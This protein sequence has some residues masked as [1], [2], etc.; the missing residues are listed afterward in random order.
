[1][2]DEPP[3]FLCTP[4]QELH[5]DSMLRRE[6]VVNE[7]LVVKVPLRFET[8]ALKILRLE[9]LLSLSLSVITM[10][11]TLKLI[12]ITIDIVIVKLVCISC[13]TVIYHS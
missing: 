6:V 12:D 5:L 4:D 10:L 1:M 3:T 11:I 2:A 8:M 7:T 9:E 13:K